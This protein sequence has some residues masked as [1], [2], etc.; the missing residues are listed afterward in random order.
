VRRDELAHRSRFVRPLK[1]GLVHARSVGWNLRGR[2]DHPGLRILFY[3]RVSDD[4]DDL[5]VTTARFRAQMEFLAAEGYSAYGVVEG[6]DLSSHNALPAKSVVL[7]FDDGYRDVQENALP[8]IDEHG[9]SATVFVVTGALEGTSSFAWYR[10]QPPLLNW[11]EVVALDRMGT[12]RF[13][14]HTIT[15]PR[16]TD[17]ATEA[18]RSEIAGSKQMLEQRLGRRV[19]AFCY[20]EGIFGRRERDLAAAAGFRVA[21]SCDPGTNDATTDAFALRRQQIEARDRLI[22][23]RAKLGGGHDSP[24]PFQRLYRRVRYLDSGNRG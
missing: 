2:A 20:P 14:S 4:R 9:F 23:F 19:E 16:L 18:A 8:V 7:S 22:D 5:A 1:A 11:D 10:R 12:L 17:L 6:F 21:V 3:H 15:H 13:E 24:L